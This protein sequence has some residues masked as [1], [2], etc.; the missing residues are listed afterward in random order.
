MRGGCSRISL[1]VSANKINSIWKLN[2]PAF[3]DDQ[4][5]KVHVRVGCKRERERE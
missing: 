1:H 3:I 5:S 2:G 4:A